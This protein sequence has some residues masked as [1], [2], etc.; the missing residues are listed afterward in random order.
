M[1]SAVDRRKGARLSLAGRVALLGRL[2]VLIATLAVGGSLLLEARAVMHG[3]RRL[4]RRDGSA[5]RIRTSSP[6]LS[7]TRI[8]ARTP[9]A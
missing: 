3:S 6:R 7:K 4:T 5:R 2:I 8:D 9:I 1:R